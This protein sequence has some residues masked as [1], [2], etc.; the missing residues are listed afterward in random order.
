VRIVSDA[1][2]QAI[3][4]ALSDVEDA[5]DSV[6]VL[7]AARLEEITK[8][9]DR[10]DQLLTAEDEARQARTQA[11]LDHLDEIQK[12]RDALAAAL[13][14]NSDLVATSLAQQESDRAELES[15]KEAKHQADQEALAQSAAAERAERRLEDLEMQNAVIESRKLDDDTKRVM[16]NLWPQIVCI[17]CGGAHHGV[18][19][20]VRKVIM[21]PN[22]PESFLYWNQWEPNPGTVWPDDVWETPAERI[23]DMEA[24][25]EARKTQVGLSQMAE[26]EARRLIDQAQRPRSPREVLNDIMPT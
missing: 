12:M 4:Q 7:A 20:R 23:A 2:W 24:K 9:E 22:G 21:T 25:A 6:Q 13:V 15:L 17:H 18:C 14:K 10:V 16:A 5:R 19:N 8:L 11:T 1:T 3:H 26:Q